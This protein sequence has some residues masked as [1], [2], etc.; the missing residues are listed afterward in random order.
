MDDLMKK[1]QRSK[2][3]RAIKSK[4]T[5]I[6][7]RLAK[8]LWHK[9]YRYRKNDKSVFGTPDLVFKKYK[10]AVFVDGEFF[11]GHDWETKKT[12]L[13]ENRDYWISKIERNME[14]DRQVNEYL[15][16]KGWKVLRFWGKDIK[17]N[18]SVCVKVIVNEIDEMR[19]KIFYLDA[20]KNL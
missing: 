15:L 16:S 3:M 7:V 12:K 18:L 4:N 19:C 11:H 8:A 1:E 10:I 13:K 2:M 9:G 14:R 17:S 5:A 6:E 20:I